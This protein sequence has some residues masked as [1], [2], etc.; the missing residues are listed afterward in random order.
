MNGKVKSVTTVEAGQVRCN[1]NARTCIVTRV[2]RTRVDYVPI[3]E[4]ELVVRTEDVRLFLGEHFYHLSDYPLK[5]AIRIYLKHNGGVSKKAREA[6]RA[7][8]ETP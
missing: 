6:L 2:G 1:H 8:K 7:L 4:G 3:E 5:K